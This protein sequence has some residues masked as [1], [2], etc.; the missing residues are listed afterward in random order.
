MLTDYVRVPA[1]DRQQE[2]HDRKVG[3]FVEWMHG[4]IGPF[5]EAEAMRITQYSRFVVKRYC[6]DALKLNILSCTKKGRT[7]TWTPL[8][9]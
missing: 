7:I 2:V 9:D 8:I 5:T 4:D 3:E 1:T 6:Q